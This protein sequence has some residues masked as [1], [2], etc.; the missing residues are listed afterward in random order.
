[1]S[2][3]T[4]GIGLLSLVLVLL[5]CLASTEIPGSL[6]PQGCRMAWMSPSYVLQSG[7][8]K[9]WSPL[10]DRYSLWLYREVGWEGTPG[11]GIPV[12]FIPGNAGSSH[13]VR[14]IAS[15]ATRQFYESPNIVSPAFS[16][17]NIK[18]LDFYTV[19]FNED[20]S[21][22][23]GPTLKSQ[24]SYSTRAIDY[25]LSQYPAGTKLI[26]M[27]HSMGGVVATSL[28]PSTNISAVI[29]MSTPHTIPPAPFDAHIA[30]VYVHNM[31]ILATDSTP[32]L[33]LCGGAADVMIRSESCILPP[34]SESNSEPIF[35]RTVF[36]S[37]LEGSWTGVGHQAMVWCHQV[38]WRVARAAL[39]LGGSTSTEAQG[40]TLDTWLRDGNHLPSHIPSGGDLLL[41]DPSSFDTLPIGQALGITGPRSSHTYLLPVPD[42]SSKFV[43]YVGKG[44][45]P[46]VAP[47]DSGPLRA[48]VYACHRPSGSASSPVCSDLSP[49]VLKL[50]PNPIPGNAFPVPDEGFAE[51][52]GVVVFEGTLPSY[53][54][55]DTWAAVHIEGASG[56]GWVAGG[57][58]ASPD[59]IVHAGG[60]LVDVFRIISVD[61]P[62]AR[63]NAGLWA[64]IHI[65]N[66]IL[67]ALVVYRILPVLDSSSNGCADAS[68]PPLLMHTSGP[69]ETHY[70][71]LM[72][73]SPHILLHSHSSAPYITGLNSAQTRGIDLTIY[74]SASSACISGLE[75][76]V[77]WWGTLGRLGSRYMIVILSWALGLIALMLLE[78]WT[79]GGEVNSLD[80]A[81]LLSRWS[82]QRLLKAMVF[83]YAFAFLPI[84]A[85][86][87][88]GT[89]GEVWLS[90]IAPL[91]LC[92]TTGL[93]IVSWWML[94]LLM[95]PIGMLGRRLPKKN[96][97]EPGRL[98]LVVSIGIIFLL[99]FLFLPW[100]IAF[101]GCWIIHL[102]TCATSQ[103]EGEGTDRADF[104][105]GDSLPAYM[106]PYS[107]NEHNH[108]M[109][110][111]LWMTWLLPLVAPVL[112]VWVRTLITAGLTVPFEGDHNF[113]NVAPFIVF[114]EFLSSRRLRIT[115][116]C[117]S[118]ERS[119][120]RGGFLI[121]AIAAF[122]FTTSSE[123]YRLFVVSS[124]HIA[125][126][127]IV[128]LV[129]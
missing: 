55:D 50:I 83:S 106:R 51:S 119:F 125:G 13:Q 28:L 87:Y 47:Q 61:L 33:S 77:D 82:S 123:T 32:I 53:Q 1:M 111:L 110:L 23:H 45:I 68:L 12:L 59:T 21:A 90:P 69:S 98:S 60:S 127:V 49:T 31:D 122:I 36:T 37:A 66:L 25:I 70:Y 30:Q 115:K 84:P 116:N 42:A 20:F 58:V 97:I 72:R 14:S 118:V 86:Y 121:L 24:I 104:V 35:R 40:D 91:L 62:K 46:P 101:L 41:Q 3:S 57:F 114:V 89:V 9:S 8:D 76:T 102:Y 39:E 112:A 11:S 43:L 109:L 95:W 38:R 5:L 15:S 63:L 85:E 79:Y 16:G 67:N 75:L 18:P 117:R 113:L 56:I 128:R 54:S 48:S 92:I 27:G 94:R 34:I 4:T 44:S 124:C 10:G 19:D 100:Q 129:F 7:L 81:Q 64:R 65:P 29:T 71:P 103:P 93:V 88:L 73:S 52:E 26:V 78:G 99:I 6:S 108:N 120:A 17:R 105:T 22:L 74:S 80:V 2:R 126:V 107:V 96:H